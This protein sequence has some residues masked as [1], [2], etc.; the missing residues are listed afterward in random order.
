M[1]QQTFLSI[2]KW[3]ASVYID[4]STSNNLQL[5]TLENIINCN[6][7]TQVNYKKQIIVKLS[8]ENPN[9]KEKS[10]DH[11]LHGAAQL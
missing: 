5:K 1:L 6:E 7:E 3:I 9:G 2:L 10:T 11:K 4:Y 8:A